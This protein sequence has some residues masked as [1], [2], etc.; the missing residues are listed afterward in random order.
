M[1]AFVAAVGPIPCYNRSRPQRTLTGVVTSPGLQVGPRWLGR[2]S[3]HRDWR[4]VDVTVRRRK[5]I[6]LFGGVAAVW[7]LAA[8]A[9]VPPKRVHQS[10]ASYRA[11]PIY[12]GAHKRKHGPH[13]SGVV[14]RVRLRARGSEIVRARKLCCEPCSL[15]VSCWQSETGNGWGRLGPVAWARSK[16]DHTP[17]WTCS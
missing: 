16:R 14:A 2:S 17:E 1:S 13:S 6:S 8:H 10:D 3:V 5:F 12:V 4:R 15:N 9:D 11:S 7:S